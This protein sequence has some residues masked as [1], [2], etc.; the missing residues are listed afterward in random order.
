MAKIIVMGDFNQYLSDCSYL[1]LLGLEEVVAEGNS[2]HRS[3]NRLDQIFTNLEIQKSELVEE[4]AGCSALSIISAAL[5]LDG[6]W[7]CQQ[8]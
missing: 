1:L 3:G 5:K 8:V 7:L 4:P 2:T 6:R